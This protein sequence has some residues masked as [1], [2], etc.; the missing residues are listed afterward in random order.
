M[1]LCYLRKGHDGTDASRPRTT[2]RKGAAGVGASRARL[3][4]SDGG[5]HGKVPEVALQFLLLKQGGHDGPH[6][7]FIGQRAHRKV[8]EDAD[9]AHPARAESATRRI[10]GVRKWAE[11]RRAGVLGF[12]LQR[13]A[14]RVRPACLRSGW[15]VPKGDI[16]TFCSRRANLTELNSPLKACHVLVVTVEIF[17]PLT[18]VCPIDCSK[19]VGE[20]L[21]RR[22]AKGK[23]QNGSDCITFPH[24]TKKKKKPAAKE[25]RRWRRRNKARTAAENT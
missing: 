10:A 19:S 7:D 5:K 13:N 3:T 24:T 20:S 12:K 21:M 4:S 14:T 17:F 22:L 11:R 23:C 2:T 16:G 15:I 1:I 6:E 18:S 9:G 25:Q 8:G